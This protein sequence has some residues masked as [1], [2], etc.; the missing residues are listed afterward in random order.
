[1]FTRTATMSKAIIVISKSV[2]P[3]CQYRAKATLRSIR[4][5]ANRYPSSTIPEAMI[6]PSLRTGDV[7]QLIAL[8]FV[9]AM[10]SSYSRW[11]VPSSELVYV[12][13]MPVNNGADSSFVVLAA[14]SGIGVLPAVAVGSHCGTASVGMTVAVG[15]GVG[16]S[17][18][19]GTISG[20]VVGASA[21]DATS[22]G[23]AGAAG[24]SVAAVVGAAVG[25]SVGDAAGGACPHAARSATTTGMNTATS[26]G[27]T[28]IRA[29]LPCGT[30]AFRYLWRGNPGAHGSQLSVSAK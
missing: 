19:F 16:T 15:A 4:G 23:T 18:G 9:S 25:I 11:P 26:F 10:L 17:G 13:I 5:L 12:R 27:R 1:M 3:S 8:A 21:S 30:A 22:E 29:T 24:V 7:V 2:P 20:V 14:G 6:T 28:S